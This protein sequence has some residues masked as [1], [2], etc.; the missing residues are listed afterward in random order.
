[1]NNNANLEDRV[2]KFYRNQD[3]VFVSSQASFDYDVKTIKIKNEFTYLCKLFSNQ[4]RT[5]S[6]SVISFKLPAIL[7]TIDLLISKNGVFFKHD[8][9]PENGCENV[10]GG[11]YKED[12]KNGKR[13]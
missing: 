7:L 2:L 3:N 12:G 11:I 6:E 8:D 10:N 5:N 4:Q 13:G 9:G 1:M